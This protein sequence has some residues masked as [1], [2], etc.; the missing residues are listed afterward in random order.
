METYTWW[1]WLSNV[2]MLNL[3]QLFYF[4]DF[5]FELYS[6]MWSNVWSLCWTH[7]CKVQLR[8][9]KEG[10]QSESVCD[11]LVLAPLKAEP[12]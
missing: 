2:F 3:V 10:I 8:A 12:P 1:V 5:S 4:S 6:V 7:G 9:N 11:W